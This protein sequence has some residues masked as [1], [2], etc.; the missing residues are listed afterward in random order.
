MIKYNTICYN[1]ISFDIIY[2]CFRII[3]F[4]K[5]TPHFFRFIWYLIWAADKFLLDESTSRVAVLQAR[6]V[7]RTHVASPCCTQSFLC[8]YCCT[9]SRFLFEKKGGKERT[10]HWVVWVLYKK[11]GGGNSNIFLFH[12]YLG[13]I[14]ILTNIIFQR[15][16]NHQLGN[17][18]CWITFG[19][20]IRHYYGESGFFLL[21]N[22]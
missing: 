4:L 17:H 2:T 6:S 13:K 14:P 1:I 19:T 3:L 21:T 18:T 10:K 5:I 12:R 15:D 11:L 7:V 8:R 9:G 20:R 22:Q 16:W